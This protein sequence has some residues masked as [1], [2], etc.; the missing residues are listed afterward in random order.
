MNRG[1]TEP[2][3][4][5]SIQLRHNRVQ[6][7]NRLE[8]P[9]D[10]VSEEA[11]ARSIRLRGGCSGRLPRYPRGRALFGF[12]RPEQSPELSETREGTAGR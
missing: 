9:L 1:G 11:F 7:Q 10:L 5:P 2:F 3:E 8:A 12:S 4:P 6:L